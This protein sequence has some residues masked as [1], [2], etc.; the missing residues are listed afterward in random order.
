MFDNDSAIAFLD[1]AT[2]SIKAAIGACPIEVAIPSLP[3]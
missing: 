1:P 2:G 3:K